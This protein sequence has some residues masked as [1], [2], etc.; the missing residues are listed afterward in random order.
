MNQFDDTSE[1]E[2]SEIESNPASVT[3]S[4]SGHYMKW[5]GIF[6]LCL[7]FASAV[8]YYLDQRGINNRKNNFAGKMSLEDRAKFW[9]EDFPFDHEK[10][11]VPILEI[12]AG[13]PKKDGIPALSKPQFIEAAKATFLRP[14]DRV[15]GVKI[16]NTARAYPI[17]ILNYHEIVNDQIGKTPIA[18]S[19]CPLCDSAVVFDRRLKAGEREFGVSGLLYNNNVLMYDRGGEPE[20][21]FSQMMTRAISGESMN[22]DLKTLPLELTTWKSWKARHPETEVLSLKTGYNRDYAA[23]PYRGYFDSPGLM[24]PMQETDVRLSVKTPVLGVWHNKTSIAFPLDKFAGKDVELQT[25]IDGVDFT[26]Q[27]EDESKSLRISEAGDGIQWAYSLWFA[28]AAFHPE[29]E[30]YSP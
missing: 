13:G 4:K 28:W 2:A 19:Y 5:S 21:L 22:E 1:T 29:T 25:S 10:L 27:Y 8:V 9:K 12:H 11:T 7:M 23:S 6:I 30:I 18:V 14:D 24:F 20:S 15:I 3:D 17:P 26:L 16:E